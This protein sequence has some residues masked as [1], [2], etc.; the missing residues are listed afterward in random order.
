MVITL[1]VAGAIAAGVAGA[2][3]AGLGVAAAHRIGSAYG[4]TVEQMHEQQRL[5]NY[6]NQ[7]QYPQHSGR[8]SQHYYQPTDYH[9]GG[10]SYGYRR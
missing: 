8:S 1:L 3:A 6:Y 7:Q 2:A 10:N 5:S 9:Y 4:M